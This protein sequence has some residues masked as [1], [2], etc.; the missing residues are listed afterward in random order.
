MF[1]FLRAGR[2]WIKTCGLSFETPL[3]FSS[4]SPLFWKDARSFAHHT[5]HCLLIRTSVRANG[6]APAYRALS[7]FAIPAFTLHLYPQFIDPVCF[8]RE[9]N[10]VFFAFTGDGNKGEAFTRKSLFPSFLQSCGEEVKAKNEKQRTR[11]LRVCV[12]VWLRPVDRCTFK[13]GLLVVD[14]YCKY[15]MNLFFLPT[16]LYFC[17]WKTSSGTGKVLIFSV[18]PLEVEWYSCSRNGIDF[19]IL[20]WCYDRK[21]TSLVIIFKV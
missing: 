11:A 4:S 18:E 3:L 2:G 5:T 7:E 9:G 12:G 19:D 21:K 6:H 15:R 10:A 16:S 1:R 14:V 8:A 13:K 20:G 17:R